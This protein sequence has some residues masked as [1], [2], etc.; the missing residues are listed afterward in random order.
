MRKALTLSAI[1][2]VAS[3]GLAAPATAFAADSDQAPAGQSAASQSAPGADT[4]ASA[5]NTHKLGQSTLS[6][7]GQT[8]QP[9]DK[10]TV[11]IKAGFPA[12][13]PDW[14]VATAKSTAFKDGKVELH[15]QGN[16]Q[17]SGTATVASVANGPYTV[18]GDIDGKTT[19]P[20]TF[21]VKQSSSHHLLGQSTLSLSGHTGQPGDK[22]TVTIKAGF[23]AE[24]PDRLVATAKSTAFKDG[25]VELHYQGNGQWSGT[26]TV[27]SVANRTYPVTGDIDGKTTNSENFTVQNC[28][29]SAEMK[30]L[31]PA[32]HICPPQTAPM[33]K[34]KPSESSAQ[35]GGQ[36]ES[37]AQAGGQSESSAQASSSNDTLPSA[38]VSPSHYQTP[39]GSVQAGMAPA[40]EGTGGMSS[41]ALGLGAV[42]LGAAGLVS[43]GLVRRHND[44]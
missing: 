37:S 20:E 38:P 17:W 16:G 7:S 26:A 24:H 11:T 8:G 33:E 21:T 31:Q 32:K 2:V 19:N 30:K 12:E 18:T 42:A 27:A 28:T 43:A 4:Q 22:V 40:A 3:I 29:C 6:L 36:S 35:A 15:Y 25:K 34:L 1:A 10:V 13:H 5:P 41:A 39:K 23:P 44:G 14:M 9:G